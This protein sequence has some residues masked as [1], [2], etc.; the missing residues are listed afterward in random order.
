M[1]VLSGKG[2]SAGIVTGRLSFFQNRRKPL[3]RRCIPVQ[4]IDAEIERFHNAL[5]KADGDLTVLYQQALEIVRR[6]DALIFQTHRM[7]LRDPD[8]FLVVEEIIRN[9]RVSA[10]FAVETVAEKHACFFRSTDN[11]VIQERAA[12]MMDIADRIIA[13]LCGVDA[14]H[15]DTRSPVIIAAEEL[16]PSET[17]RFDRSR[18]LA[19]ITCCGS[20]TSHAAILAST[21]GIPAVIGVGKGIS[22]AD[23][24]KTVAVDAENG[25]VYID[26]D[27]ETM[28]ELLR[29]RDRFLRRQSELQKY[30]EVPSVTRSGQRVRLLANIAAPSDID[31]VLEAGAEGIGLFRSEFLYL[32]R[33]SCPP[34]EEQFSVYRD[35]LRRMQNRR[36]VIRTPD[37]GADKLAD[38]LHMPHEENPALGCRGIRLCL[39]YPELFRTQLRAVYR[40]GVFGRAAI[41]LPMISDVEEVRKARVLMNEV[42]QELREQ[43]I[44]FDPN[45]QI[46]AMIETPAAALI[47]DHLAQEVDFF[48][49]G[50]NDLSQYTLA[51]DR[52]SSMAEDLLTECHPAVLALIEMAI[53]SAHRRH[54]P[55]CICGEMA[56]DPLLTQ[57]FLSY[58]VDELS[59]PA[60]RILSLRRTVT[61]ME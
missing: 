23:D 42:C 4:Q 52:Q 37:L 36:V 53:N 17:I 40:A 32:D 16:S 28:S 10:E 7:I 44:P 25:C 34:E 1:V 60:A 24:G 18:V 19:F 29:K 43:N 39:K 45:I 41:L 54:I 26:P 49:I 9:D 12:D 15:F 59:V 46:G 8:F 35:I 13:I 20:E 56:G 6:E 22:P 5:D 55:A 2:V 11:A 27:A 57:T 30:R 31:A 51:V 47:S 3:A 38:C 58:G 14:P 50:T 61:E 21:M 33:S 48:S